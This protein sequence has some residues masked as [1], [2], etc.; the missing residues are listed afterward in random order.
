MALDVPEHSSPADGS[1]DIK[2]NIS[3]YIN[4]VSG[5][6]SYQYM[7]DT[8][9]SFTSPALRTF[10]HSAAYSGWTPED[11]F[12]NTTY[13]WKIRACNATD[14][15]AWSSA[16]SFTTVR[17]GALQSSPPDNSTNQPVKISLMISKYGADNYDYQLDTVPTFDSP[18]LQ[19]ASHSS[20]YDGNTFSDL[21]Y[22]QKYYWRVRGRNNA[23]TS[24]WSDAWTF[25]TALYGV[26]NS[27]PANGATEGTKVALYINRLS[28]SEN[29]DY[30]LD[31][32]QN[33]DSPLLREVSHS[34]VYSGYTFYNLMYNTTYYWHARGRNDA[35]TSIWT[36]VWSFSTTA[37]GVTQNSPADGSTNQGT[38]LTLW[39]DIVSGTD[40]IDYQIDTVQTFDSPALLERTH[41]D[42]YSGQTISDLL[43]NQTYYWRVRG[44]NDS[45]TS[46]WT[47]IWVFSTANFGASQ[48]SPADG[49]IDKD[50][51]LTL[52]VDVLS[53]SDT[54]DYMLDTSSDYSSSVAARYSH[55]YEYTGKIVDKL[56][57]GTKYYW[58]V[59]G[60]NDN[61]TSIWTDSWTFVTDT[62]GA[63]PN[64]PVN[65]AIGVSITP[66]LW[67]DACDGN[68]SLDFQID[69]NNLFN[70]TQI[71][72]YSIG[73]EYSGLN[74]SR[75][76]L[77]YG[78]TY[79]W[80]VRGRHT[81]DT[82]S[83]SYYYKFTT[84]YQLSQ[85]TLITPANDSTNAP[86]SSLT[87]SWNTLSDADD[88]Q[89]QVS[90]DDDFLN[91]IKSGYTSLTFATVTDLYPATT[92]YWRVRGQNADGFSPWTDIWH[93]TTK[94]VPLDIPQLIF[95]ANAQTNM[96]L[97]I[98]FNWNTVYG[99]NQYIM[100][101]SPNSDFATY[102]E[103]NT[104]DTVVSITGLSANTQYYWRVMASDGTNQSDWSDAW[105]FSTGSGILTTPELLLP[106]NMT[107]NSDTATLEFVWQLVADAE[108]YEIQIAT[109][110][111]FLNIFY[112]SI[113][114]DT[115]VN[116]EHF[117]CDEIYFWR[118]KAYNQYL[119]SYWSPTWQFSTLPCENY[120]GVP[121][122]RYP[123]N[124]SQDIDTTNVE[125]QWSSVDNATDYEFQLSTNQDFSN[126]VID[127]TVQA[128]NYNFYNLLHCTDYYWRVRAINASV[129][130]D[131]SS[132]WYFGTS[133]CVEVL[134][135]SPEVKMYPNPANDNVCISIENASCLIV[136]VV[137]SQGRLILQQK[138]N[139]EKLTL[140]L[141]GLTKGIYFVKI[142]TN[143]FISYNK[144]IVR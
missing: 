36:D 44:R 4:G 134:E 85:P 19:E 39:V 69:T 12:F 143:D 78:T 107:E 24:E 30:Q 83:W 108:N 58:K 104:S 65:D 56:F 66:T 101:I 79:Y 111:A 11:L 43:Y 9:A 124:N 97:D 118:V 123:E 60:R 110:A 75:H 40:S 13:F 7:L 116:V 136:S 53:G 135:Q 35:D 71:Q 31:T 42:D 18:A 29:I 46:D 126:I 90:T 54:I 119:E 128:T 2:V 117:S 15:S 38:K 115:F 129:Y 77:K 70:S 103:F 102:S 52:W 47:G 139:S 68:D 106:V 130:G 93:F 55:S 74:M 114:T 22:N 137:D 20:S 113:T 32:S 14:T 105:T 8:S 99:A 86:F 37:L 92:Y 95:P 94:S 140:D 125:F 80:R 27:S 45:D 63:T 28:G 100:Q 76:Q 16:W 132:A 133:G 112:S 81:I 6:T 61:D 62:T 10:E 57:Y 34:D 120:V 87:L 141:S 25:T 49:S 33:F 51:K 82:A 41:S 138:V 72:E 144:L 73:G 127:T 26:T 131:W 98:D 89:Y 5:A 84:V 59:R 88:Y 109:D 96:P 122:L 64:S 3:L 91:I 17:Y 142:E 121:E 48:N 67:V 1:S 23:D 21:M 50:V